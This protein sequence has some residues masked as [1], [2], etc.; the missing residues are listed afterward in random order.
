MS[1]PDLACDDQSGSPT[2]NCW[3]TRNI[4]VC[5]TE[6]FGTHVWSQAE[7]GLNI[8]SATH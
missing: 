7:V 8:D 2:L 4:E 5:V 6:W 1:G 3:K